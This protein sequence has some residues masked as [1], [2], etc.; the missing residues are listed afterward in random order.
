M[1]IQ[2]KKPSTAVRATVEG[3]ATKLQ[4]NY[5]TNSLKSVNKYSNAMEEM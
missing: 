3:N 2:N 1:D 5:S 4:I